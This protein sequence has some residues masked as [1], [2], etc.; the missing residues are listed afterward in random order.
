MRNAISS[1]A[2]FIAT[3]V[4]I[5][6]NVALAHKTAVAGSIRDAE[7]EH[8]IR[9]YA[10]PLLIAAG[11]APEDVKLHII[12]DREINAFVA[13]GQRI[14]VTSGLLMAADR[15]EQVMG[16]LAHEI[17]HIAGGHLAR[18]S[19]ALTDARRQALIGEVIGLAFG[20]LAKDS[21]VT[22][23]TIAKSSEI[24]RRGV[25]KFS[26]TQERSADQVAVNLLEKTQTSAIGLLEFFESLQNQELLV[27][28]RQ[29]TYVATHPRTQDRIAFVRKHI[30]NSLYSETPMPA[31]VNVMHERMSAKLKGFFN[32]TVQ[33]LR[34][35]PADNTAI[36]ARYAR[37]MAHYRDARPEEALKL[38]DSL[39]EQI[40]NDPYF[41]ELRGQILFEQGKLA[42][43]LPNYERAVALR[44]QEPL[45]RVGLAHVQVE[46]NTPL[47]VKAA[48]SNL[49]QALRFDKVMPLTWQLAAIAYGRDGKLGLSALALSEYHQLLGR[50]LDAQGQ[51]SKAARILPENS[52]AWVRAQ[53]I[54]NSS[55][56][57]RNQKRR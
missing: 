39:L 35:F 32:P 1:H 21:S 57:T 51:A 4:T 25:F 5:S 18:L 42:E 13:R 37:A 2:A 45:L 55:T 41:H 22:A 44:P 11:F 27:R 56:P 17:G 38:I 9:F 48:I 20:A 8:T 33:T 12:N 28:A 29:D 46:L 6:L 15:P 24:A 54:L 31:H 23:T 19:G 16:V 43:A 49:E 14:F 52:P 7:I 30:K 10:S 36:S 3:I 47:L 53:D 34:E 50:D 26:R 40:P